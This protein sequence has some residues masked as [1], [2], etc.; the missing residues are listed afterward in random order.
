MA[1]YLNV[2]VYRAFHE[3]MGRGEVL[4]E[5][6]EQWAAGDRKGSLA[7]IPDN[8]VDDLIVHGDPDA[9]R[10]HLDRYARAGVTTSAL[11]LMGLPGLDLRQ[12]VR[13]LAPG[14]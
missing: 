12:A 2:P 6:W 13:D 14:R 8:V 9:C 1:A 11:M 7:K 10:A 4:A 5:H 3:W